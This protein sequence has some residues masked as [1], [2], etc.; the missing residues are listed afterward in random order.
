MKFTLFARD[1]NGGVLVE[2]TIMLTVV[3]LVIIGVVDFLFAFYQWNAATKAVEI[4]ARVAAVSDPVAI[5]LDRTQ[6]R[7]DPCA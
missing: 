4:G 6:C 5:G 3:L 7:Y 2:V 1:Q